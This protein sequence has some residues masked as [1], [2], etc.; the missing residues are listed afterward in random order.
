MRSPFPLRAGALAACLILFGAR[1]GLA[2]TQA[3]PIDTTSLERRPYS[4]M[5]MLFEKTI[6]KVDV[7]T[8]EVR[9]G[10][11]TARRLGAFVR[12]LGRTSEAKDSIAAVATHA[13]DA[14]ARIEFKRDV[15]LSQ[16]LDGVDDNMRRAL[17]AGIIEEPDYR[18]V[19][20]GMPRWFAFLA[21]DGIRKGDQV[22]YR[23]R[24]DTLRT[25]FRTAEG[26]V[27][28]DQKD[29]GPERR[30]TLLGS[31]FA[32]KSNFRDKLI[33]SLFEEAAR[34]AEPQ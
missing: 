34:E 31:Y 14:W 29:V 27:R 20:D 6:F 30:L 5:R 7:L 28:L 16:F 3:S 1:A 13:T 22:L 18:L 33:R 9:F 10:E 21:E 26:E 4:E 17:E 11:E 8:L 2:A 23:I 19:A 32:P 12:E 24:G 15:S 25:V